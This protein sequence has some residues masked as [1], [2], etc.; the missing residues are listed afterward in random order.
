MVIAR[1]LTNC[2]T[3]PPGRVAKQFL[4]NNHGGLLSD[5]SHSPFI[6]RGYVTKV[7]RPAMEDGHKPYNHTSH[8]VNGQRGPRVL[9]TNNSLPHFQDKNCR[10]GK[11][12][13]DTASP[14]VARIP[15]FPSKKHFCC[16]VRHQ[17]V[18]L[19]FSMEHRPLTHATS[20]SPTHNS[21]CRHIGNQRSFPIPVN[22]GP[23]LWVM[24]DHAIMAHRNL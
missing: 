17:R 13:L 10:L 12:Q 4:C 3:K 20:T 23:T 11:E 2:S 1:V 9:I 6:V 8:A 16:S 19:L 15:L 21:H 7:D 22:S 5:S 14:P 24:S 18:F